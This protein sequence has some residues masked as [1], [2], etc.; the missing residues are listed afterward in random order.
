MVVALGALQPRAEK[1]LR[2]RFGPCHGIAERAIVIRRRVVVGAADRADQ[3][4]RE[5]IQR[6]VVG[7]A[8]AEPLMQRTHA[9]NIEVLL[10]LAQQIGPA[11]G[12]Q[13][14][15]LWPREPG[16]DQL[17]LFV[18][19]LVGDERCRFSGPSAKRPAHRA[20]GGG[21]NSA[22][23]AGAL[24]LICNS[25]RRACTCTISSILFRLWASFHRNSARC[26]T[27]ATR[28]GFCAERYRTNTV[29]SPSRTNVAAPSG[30]IVHARFNR[31]VACPASDVLLAAIA[32]RGDDVELKAIFGCAQDQVRWRHADRFDPRSIRRIERRAG[33][34]PAAEQGRLGA[35]PFE[36]LPPFVRDV[37]QRLGQEQAALRVKRI[38]PAAGVFG[39]ECFVV[40]FGVLIAQRKLESPFPVAF[41]MARTRV[42][43]GLAQ[44]A[45]ISMLKRGAA[46]GAAAWKIDSS[47]ARDS[48]A[49]K[50]STEQS[51][52]KVG[53]NSRT[54]P[55]NPAR[56][57][58]VTKAPTAA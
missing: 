55:K 32:E 14:G 26:G 42:A 16:I 3:L 52:S 49:G 44:D 10:F 18:W 19:C 12:P 1:N 39:N 48:G 2:R 58:P 15:I 20:R 51:A 22:S 5:L 9:F 47:L 34:N 11:Q 53:N 8:R 41:A 23:L 4:A 29:V 33:S 46:S 43:A 57:Q 37:H 40:E 38:D 36:A 56:S 50:S 17:H 30:V 21:L 54:I 31:I 27:S 25:R 7:E 45:A 24:G 28:T 13:L 6:P 35:I